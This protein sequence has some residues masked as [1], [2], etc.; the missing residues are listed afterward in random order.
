MCALSFIG[1]SPAFKSDQQWNTFVDFYLISDRLLSSLSSSLLSSLYASFSIFSF[2]FFYV[3]LYTPS[4]LLC[5]MLSHSPTGHSLFINRFLPFFLFLS[6]LR[7][8]LLYFVVE[9]PTLPSSYPVLPSHYWTSI[10]PTSLIPIRVFAL[11]C[12]FSRCDNSTS[13][14][15]MYRQNHH[16]AVSS[17]F[18]LKND[19]QK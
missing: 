10:P 1:V 14:P 15:L 16:L 2:I 13:L 4:T 5:F 17:I 3:S 6:S 8:A 19:C 11:S 7:F 12:Y 9:V 18:V